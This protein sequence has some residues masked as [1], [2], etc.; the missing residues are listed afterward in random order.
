MNCCLMFVDVY[1]A[2]WSVLQRSKTMDFSVL[3]DLKTEHNKKTHF[4]T[5]VFILILNF[6]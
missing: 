3:F 5:I 2:V 1:R 6:K 4:T